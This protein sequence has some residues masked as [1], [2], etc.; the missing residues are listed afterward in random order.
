MRIYLIQI[1]IMKMSAHWGP[2]LTLTQSLKSRA[3]TVY[4][5]QERLANTK[6]PVDT[7]TVQAGLGPS[8]R[9]HCVYVMGVV[10]LPKSKW[11][12]YKICTRIRKN[13]RQKRKYTKQN[14]FM[15]QRQ[16]IHQNAA[17]KQYFFFNRT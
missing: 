1:V 6:T 10:K 4:L 5:L 13:I 15:Q 7:R 12:E 8:H 3:V 14:H 2:W 17:N 11:E 9:V 16:T